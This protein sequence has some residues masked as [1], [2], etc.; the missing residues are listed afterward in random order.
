MPPPYRSRNESDPFLHNIQWMTKLNILE[1]ALSTTDSNKA[2]ISGLTDSFHYT[3]AFVTWILKPSFEQLQTNSRQL[4]GTSIK[5]RHIRR[6][7]SAEWRVVSWHSK[8]VAEIFIKVVCKSK[9]TWRI[10]EVER[11]T[12]A[13]HRPRMGNRSLSEM[14]VNSSWIHSNSIPH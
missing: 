14:R 8:S 3:S 12:N 6:I 4:L 2:A 5:D 10:L 11:T 7:F 1:Q 13:Q 9:P